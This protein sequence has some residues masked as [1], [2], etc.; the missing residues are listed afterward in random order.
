MQ[1]DVKA[2]EIGGKPVYLRAG[3]QE[4]L[5]GSQR[6]VSPLE[7]ANTRRTFQGFR[8]MWQGETV[9]ADLFWV[10]PIVPNRAELDSVDNNQNFA[11]VYTTTKLKNNA[12]LDLYY[13]LLD[14]TNRLTQQGIVR[15]QTTANTIGSR[16]WQVFDNGILV[17]GEGGMQLGSVA[18]QNLIAG[19]ASGGVGY[20]WKDAPLSPT[21][22]AY[23]D[24][25]SGDED[26]NLGTA[27]TFNQLFPFGHNYLGWADL[28][29]R[30][31]IHDFNLHMFLY[32]TKWMTVWLQY[33]RFWLDSPKDA[34]YNA[35]G[36]AYRR[37]ATGAAGTDVGHEVDAIV[38]FHVTK[39]SDVMTGYSHLFG[40]DFLQRTA[41]PNAAVDSSFFFVQYSY[42]W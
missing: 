27:H 11:G 6:L 1:I 16:Y 37:D 32:P 23:Y 7:W 41:G 3:R 34:L 24:Y 30:Q 26:P 20:N 14:D 5:F 9:T 35:G 36:V 31:N 28:V 40:G 10:Q 17:E 22:W 15:G 29:G 21:F 8:G 42:R 33:H 25:A 12:E 2:A 19:Y 18:G 4:L 39:H 13:F 38:N